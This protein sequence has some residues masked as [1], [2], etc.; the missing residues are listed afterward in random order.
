MLLGT[1]VHRKRAPKL[2]PSFRQPA[3]DSIYC[4]AHSDRDTEPQR[5]REYEFIMWPLTKI[6]VE[7]FNMVHLTWFIMDSF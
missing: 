1:V 5:N 4:R 6:V 3:L 2:M 7:L